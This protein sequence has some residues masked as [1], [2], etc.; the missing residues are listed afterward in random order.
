MFGNT[1]SN[2]RG[3][4]LML[5]LGVGAV[6]LMLSSTAGAQSWSK[7][8][9]VKFSEPVEIPGV[10]AQVLPPGTYVFKLLDSASDRHIVQVFNQKENHIFATIL[11]IPNYRL[12]ATDKTVMTFE[13]RAAGRAA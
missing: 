6:C 9:T 10:G 4:A 13:E 1:V 7:K 11:A 12:K 5:S 3:R 8:T 2:R